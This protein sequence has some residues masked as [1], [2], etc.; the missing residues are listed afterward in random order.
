M[1][2][3]E[4]WTKWESRIVNGVFPLLRFLGKSNHSVVFLTEVGGSANAAIKLIPA[5]PGQT[6]AQLSSWRAV[7]TLSHPHLIRLLDVGR[8]QLGGYPFLFVVMEHAE[9]TLAQILPHRTLSG[10]EVREMLLPTLNALAFLH[11]K[12]LV[13]GQLKPPNFLVVNDQLKLASDTI[14]PAGESAS[15]I[16]KPS[17]YD[18]PEANSGGF[19]AAGDIWGLGI[20]IAEALTQCPPAWP[21]ERSEIVSL[22]ATLSPPF[23]DIVRQCLSRNPDDRPT[24]TDL[25]AHV[26]PLQQAPV[27]SVAQP[28]AHDAAGQAARTREAPKRLWFVPVLALGLLV[29]VGVWAALHLFQSDRKLQQ[30]VSSASP[31]ASQQAAPPA[32]EPQNPKE[33][34]S[35]SPEVSGPL[36]GAR[37]AESGPALSRTVSRAGDQAEPAPA[38]VPPSVLHQE[39]PAV[40]RSARESIHGHIKVTVRVTVDRSGEVVGETV[41]DSSSSKYFARVATEAARKWRFVPADNQTSREWLL[42]FEFTRDGTTARI[43][44]P[45]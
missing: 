10:E 27:V 8:C 22:P 44:T 3:T 2:M 5:D 35:A 19:S 1:T 30:S 15:G 11:R 14:R 16:A 18:P 17:P 33:S 43:S 34:P 37:S 21:D 31:T 13:H 24:I 36:S 38:D 25:E 6:E 42:R 29:L 40:L 4:D 7:A 39:I 41:Q 9:Q 32:A 28:V 12:N 23:V 20:V 45:R 26:K